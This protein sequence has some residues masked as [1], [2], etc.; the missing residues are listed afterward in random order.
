MNVKD[1]YRRARYSIEDLVG[2]SDQRH[3][4]NPWPLG[5]FLCAFRPSGNTR[6]D[7]AKSILERLRSSWIMVG[8]VG[9]AESASVVYTTLIQGEIFER[10]G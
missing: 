4:A 5:N 2:I 8:D 3:D 1:F 9:E 6:N 10:L 7:G